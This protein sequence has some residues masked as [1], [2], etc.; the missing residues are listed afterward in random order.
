[1]KVLFILSHYPGFGGIE[2]VTDIVS[3]YLNECG[4]CVTICSFGTNS[5]ELCAIYPH[6]NR[7]LF[8]PEPLL[9]DSAAN[10]D[11]VRDLLNNDNYDFVIFQDSYAPLENLL[12]SIDYP[13]TAKLI[14]VEHN[15]PIYSLITV[16]SYFFIN[17]SLSWIIGRIIKYIPSIIHSFIKSRNRHILLLHKSKCYI[18]LS[19]AYMR[20]IK[21]LTGL[22]YMTKVRVIPNPLTIPPPKVG[23]SFQCKK[24][25]Q[26]LFVGR[27]TNQK[28]LSLLLDI[29]KQFCAQSAG[30]NLIV[31]GDGPEKQMIVDRISR[32]GLRGIRIHQPTCDV[33]KYYE[34]SQILMMTSIY[35][36]FPL[37]LAES[38][39][40]YC[41]PICFDSFASVYD[42]IHD[43]V[44][45]RI[46][47]SFDVRS[48]CRA[49]LKLTNNPEYLHSLSV[50]AANTTKEFSVQAI[51]DK[52]LQLLS[53]CN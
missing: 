52:W 19:E 24:I 22:R 4:I 47:K 33:V 50:N 2:K 9:Y 39:S 11:F 5:P 34:E 17:K 21:F 30:W 7:V 14:T 10:K 37:V 16:N 12:F 20:D 31:L 42:I 3:T 40:R 43:D 29:W 28:G 25:K 32:E 38:M 15:T 18:I 53:G 48:Y 13:W 6:E 49:L 46:I 35:E 23:Y 26:I 27:L 44:N 36:G 51:G 1:M 41:V 45:G 8:V